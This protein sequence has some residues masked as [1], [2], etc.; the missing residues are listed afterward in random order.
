MM[1]SDKFSNSG[2]AIM[3]SKTWSN[4]DTIINGKELRSDVMMNDKELIN[5]EVMMNDRVE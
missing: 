4:N 2:A 1:N 5:D 3:N